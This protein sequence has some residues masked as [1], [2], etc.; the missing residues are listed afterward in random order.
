MEASLLATLQP[1]GYPSAV[2]HRE[3]LRYVRKSEGISV[4]EAKR[5]YGMLT[6]VEWR[7]KLMNKQ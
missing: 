5:R 3:L 4:S 1:D 2:L 7:T 6:A